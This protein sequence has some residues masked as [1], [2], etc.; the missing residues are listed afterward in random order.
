VHSLV[1]EMKLIAKKHGEHNI[2]FYGVN[3]IKYVSMMKVATF[4]TF[5]L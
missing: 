1:K 4:I 2:K 3:S 5:H